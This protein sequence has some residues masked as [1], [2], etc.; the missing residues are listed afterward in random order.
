MAE[1]LNRPSRRSG[2][3]VTNVK[4]FTYKWRFQKT[5]KKKN[6][7][8]CS[9]LQWRV[10]AIIGRKIRIQFLAKNWNFDIR[11]FLGE[12][13]C[14]FYKCPFFLDNLRLISKFQFFA[15]NLLIFSILMALIHHHNLV[16]HHI[17]CN[18]LPELI[19]WGKSNRTRLSVSTQLKQWGV[20][21]FLFWHRLSSDPSAPSPPSSSSVLVLLASFM[22]QWRYFHLIE[23]KSI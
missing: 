20:S 16:L 5:Q 11:N 7:R 22:F 12:K 19:T 15:R 10:R 13:P 21:F 17:I 2:R 23:K 8:M 14:K 4:C 18:L 6:E 1:H 3:R 9:L